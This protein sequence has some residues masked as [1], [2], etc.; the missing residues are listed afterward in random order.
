MTKT[1]HII[2]T[3]MT[4]IIITGSLFRCDVKEYNNTSKIIPIKL[5]VNYNNSNIIFDINIRRTVDKN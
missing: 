2:Q 5:N 4:E 1:F 3:N